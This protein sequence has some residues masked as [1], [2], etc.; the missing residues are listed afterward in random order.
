MGA[1][2]RLLYDRPKM[3][4][5]KGNPCATWVLMASIHMIHSAAEYRAMGGDGEG[6][7]TIAVFPRMGLW[8]LANGDGTKP[9]YPL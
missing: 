8:L 4:A 6:R 1:S 2:D 7:L 3:R 5:R 9:P